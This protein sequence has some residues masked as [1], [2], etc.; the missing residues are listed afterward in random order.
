MIAMNQDAFKNENEGLEKLY[1]KVRE[2]AADK[3]LATLRYQLAKFT[4]DTFY[5]TGEELHMIGS[6]TGASPH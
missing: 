6:K 2:V 3:N 5:Q 4:G 1:E